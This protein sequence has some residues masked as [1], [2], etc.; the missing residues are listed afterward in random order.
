MIPNTEL[1][2]RAYRALSGS[3]LHALSTVFIVLMLQGIAGSVYIGIVVLGALSIGQYMYFLHL[4]RTQTHPPLETIFEGFKPSDR[5]IQSLI[6]IILVT[7]LVMFGTLLLVIP[8]IIAGIGLSMTFFVMADDPGIRA[9]DAMRRSWEMVWE[10]GNFWK[11]FG[12]QL[13]AIPLFFLGTLLLVVGIFFVMPI[14]YTALAGLYDTL[15][16]G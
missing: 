2:S 14:Y 1:Y 13:L 5:F 12:F 7:L 8:G 3:W 15:N 11:V 6:A 4:S 16:G 10:R 9:T